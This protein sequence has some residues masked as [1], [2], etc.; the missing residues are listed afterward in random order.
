MNYFN[1]SIRV[2]I[3]LLLWLP[4][5]AGVDVTASPLED[6]LRALI[7]ENGVDRGFWGVYVQD[8]SS[9]EALASIDGDKPFVPAS[10]QKLLTSAAALEYLGPDHRFRTILYLDGRIDGSVF[11][12]RLIIRGSGDPTFG[13]RQ[14][15]GPDPLRAWA[16]QLAEMGITEIRG[17]IVGDDSRFDG[18]PYAEGWDVEHVTNQASR[19]LGVSAG[20]LAYYDN[21]LHPHDA[22]RKAAQDHLKKCI[23]AAAMLGI[24]RVGTFVGARAV[25]AS[26][27][28]TEAGRF[29]RRLCKYADDRGVKV[30]IENCPMDN[31][32]RFGIPGN[33]AY[34]PELWEAL[35]NEVPNENFGLNID[36]SHLYWL[37]IDYVKAVRDFG[38]R[39]FHAH[40]KD[41]EIL[42]DGKY[43]HGIL[44]EQ[45]GD[46]P[47]R[48]GWWRFRMPGS[49]EIDWKAFIAALKEVGYDDVLSI[50]HEDPEYEGSKS[51]VKEGLGKGMEYL[52]RITTE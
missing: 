43:R 26:T 4:A 52:S 33:F 44:S 23:D 39:I 10:N 29:F 40:A 15:P 49:G 36:P 2:I 42:S 1:R 11:R 48:S 30:M 46:N 12:G 3:F 28:L 51:K 16:Q 7:S 9:G 50:E 8:L 35:F 22:K 18:E 17:D 20:A 25:R 14:T 27:V 45:L 24:D 21:N 32:V 13:S 31:W 37:G 38:D 5:A 41:T 47:W 19:I 34:S 6:R